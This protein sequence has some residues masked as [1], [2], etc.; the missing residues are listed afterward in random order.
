VPPGRV[1]AG[2]Q[3]ALG[4]LQLQHDADEALRQGVV[5][6]AGEALALGQPPRLPLRGG[7]L[8]AGRL[9]LLDQLPAAGALLDDAGDPDG[10]QDPEQQ[11][12]QPAADRPRILRQGLAGQQHLAPDDHHGERDRAEDGGPQVQQAEDL[13]VQPQ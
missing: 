6:V 4:G 5:D 1:G 9:Q 7:Q 13:R 10:E 3:L 11:R 8:A 12:Q 2:R